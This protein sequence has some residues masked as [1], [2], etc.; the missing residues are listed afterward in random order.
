MLLV[1]RLNLIISAIFFL[2]SCGGKK[3]VHTFSSSSPSYFSQD[4]IKLPH[5]L[6][7]PPLDSSILD[8]LMSDQSIKVYVGKIK[9]YSITTKGNEGDFVVCSS[10]LP[11][12]IRITL[13]S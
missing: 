13:L 6:K 4:E 7:D 12:N 3:D 5:R 10:N 2:I 8:N 11:L 1:V 9:R